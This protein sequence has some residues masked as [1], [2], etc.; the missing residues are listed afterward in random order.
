MFQFVGLTRAQLFTTAFNSTDKRGHFPARNRAAHIARHFNGGGV[1]VRNGSCKI[2]P[3][4]NSF[5]VRILDRAAAD[6][7]ADDGVAG[8]E[9]VVGKLN[10][11]EAFH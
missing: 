5:V 2:H 9:V 6:K 11:H 10:L 1:L 7:F 3:S 8:D 4:E